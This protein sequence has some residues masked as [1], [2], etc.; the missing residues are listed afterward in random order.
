VNFVSPPKWHLAHAT[1]FGGIY[2]DKICLDYSVYNEDFHFFNS[3]YNNVG[4]R[5]LRPSR[6]LMT[7]PSVNEVYKY[8]KYVT[9]AMVAF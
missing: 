8:R 2:I 1:W 6:G 3:Y 9:D 4:K 5:V 7:R